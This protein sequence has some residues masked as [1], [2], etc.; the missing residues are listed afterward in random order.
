MSELVAACVLLTTVEA[1]DLEQL[2]TRIE[3]G[4]KTFV[5]V[6]M[7]LAEI[8]ERK[9]YRATHATF[10]DYCRERWGMAR[11]T[12]YQFMDAAEVVENVRNCGQILPLNEAQAR[13]LTSL[14]SDV[15]PLVW[16]VAVET[17]PPGGI[18]AR[19]VERVVDDYR[20]GYQFLAN[21]VKKC[22]VCG[23]LW[24]AD[25][26]YCPYCNIPREERIAYV[27]G[28]VAPE[29]PHVSHNSGNNEWY[30]PPEYIYAAR[31]VMGGIDLDPATSE[32]ANK[33]VDA[34][35]F[36]TAEDDGLRQPWFGRVWMNPPYAS[37]LVGRFVDRLA[38]G[39]ERGDITEAVV[40]VNNATETA[41][42]NR[43]MGVASAVCFPRGRVRFWQPGGDTGAPLQGQA[44]VYCGVHT[45]KFIE[46]FKGFGWI[47]LVTGA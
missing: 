2:E 16:Q 14:P 42:F 9:L 17:A 34:E 19:H 27:L 32:E 44:V 40:L 13:P 43:L 31:L 39:V 41:W 28:Q 45:A 21:D 8:R 4:I 26:D 11:S 6:G 46:E 33:V 22:N 24:A 25:L 15:Q 29:M 23:N 36:Y 7:A 12:A 20:N 5:D 47:A 18:T 38:S 30:T 3:R 10:E 35:R 1:S 37:D